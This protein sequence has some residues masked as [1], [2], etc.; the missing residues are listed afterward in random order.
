[1]I[2]GSAGN[3]QEATPKKQHSR[4]NTRETKAQEPL[5]P[6]P[7]TVP[8]PAPPA[9]PFVAPF[10]SGTSFG[11]H[12][13]HTGGECMCPG[14][15]DSGGSATELGVRWE[16]HHFAPLRRARGAG[17]RDPVVNPNKVMGA[18]SDLARGGVDEVFVNAA[19][20]PPIQ[21]ADPCCLGVGGRNRTTGPTDGQTLEKARDKG[22]LR[23]GK[24]QHVAR[25]VSIHDAGIVPRPGAG[26][27]SRD[28]PSPAKQRRVV[29]YPCSLGGGRGARER[30]HHHEQE[31][32]RH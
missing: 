25:W 9:R 18:P 17:D 5:P 11:L 14:R 16:R 31:T 1:M 22:S 13:G 2:Q 10:Y 15:V 27:K 26:V 32:H 23:Q 24:L 28:R 12:L 20:T 7:A 21:W 6:A 29:R 4:G 3:A 30:R 8:A 19:R